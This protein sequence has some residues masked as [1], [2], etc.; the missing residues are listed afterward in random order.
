MLV[1][2]CSHCA[3]RFRVTPQQ[4]N[5]KQGQVLCGRCHKV[6]NGFES[7][8]RF[9]DDD[10]GARLLAQRNAAETV[11]PRRDEE[12]VPKESLPETESVGSAPPLDVGEV[13]LPLEPSSASV[14]QD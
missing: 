12:P 1:T 14:A 8:E 4:L 9:P 6:F 3:S 5:E 2:T 11:I 7:L 10:T 13:D